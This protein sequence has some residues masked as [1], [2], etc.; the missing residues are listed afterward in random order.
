MNTDPIHEQ[1]HGDH[2]KAFMFN[3]QPTWL[4]PAPFTL[5]EMS[6]LLF[7]RSRREHG[8]FDDD[9]QPTEGN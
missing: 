5:A 1:G 3:Q 2:D 9:M 4:K 8:Q 7:Q 6:H